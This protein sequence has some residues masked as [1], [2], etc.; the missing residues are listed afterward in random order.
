MTNPIERIE[1]KIKHQHASIST[2]EQHFT[3]KLYLISVL[4]SPTE[5]TPLFITKDATFG[6]QHFNQWREEFG[7]GGKLAKISELPYIEP[8][9]IE[10]HHK[11]VINKKLK[12]I[13]K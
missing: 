13:K 4:I 12:E 5:E 9:P 1:K 7:F 6:I 10:E 3:D 11:D 8:I 2:I